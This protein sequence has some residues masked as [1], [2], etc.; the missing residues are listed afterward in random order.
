M[1][2]IKF[3]NLFLITA[4]II[5]VAHRNIYTSVLLML[6]SINMLIDVIPKLR[7]QLKK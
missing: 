3:N 6:A 2:R 5:F 1:K 7:K 4:L